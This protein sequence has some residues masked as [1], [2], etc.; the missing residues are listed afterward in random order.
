VKEIILEDGEVCSNFDQEI[1]DTNFK[2]FE[3]LYS[4]VV[5]SCTESQNQ[6]L[7]HISFL[8]ILEDNHSI[9]LSRLSKNKFGI[10]FSNM[11]QTRPWGHTGSRVIFTKSVGI[12]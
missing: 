11:T 4:E 2:H 12:S 8:V 1:K 10:L 9:S 5:P 7:T 3:H 6:L